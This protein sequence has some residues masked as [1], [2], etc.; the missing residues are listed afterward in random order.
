MDRPRRLPAA[1]VAAAALA[2]APAACGEDDVDDARDKANDAADSVKT[3]AEDL[4]SSLDSQR[5]R[6][7]KVRDLKQGGAPV[8]EEGQQA[9]GRSA[10]RSGGRARGP[11]R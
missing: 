6:E 2:L 11:G 4:K 5:E 8:R 1:L 7:A 3:E 9:R 10:P